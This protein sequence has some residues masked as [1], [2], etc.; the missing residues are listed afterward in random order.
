MN[1]AFDYLLMNKDAQPPN[2]MNPDNGFQWGN[3]LFRSA[4][5]YLS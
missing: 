5:W 4:D 3:N 2:F 1:K